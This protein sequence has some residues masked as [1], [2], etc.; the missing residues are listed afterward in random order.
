MRTII[1]VL[2]IM[3]CLMAMI[4]IITMLRFIELI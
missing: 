2:D 3:L 4:G 1:M